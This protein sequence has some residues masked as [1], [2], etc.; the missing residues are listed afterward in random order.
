MDLYRIY[1]NDG[2]LLYVGISYST[3]QRLGQHKDTQHWFE[4][5]ARIERQ[6]LGDISRQ[7]ALAIEAQVITAER[8][9]YNK[10][11]NRSSQLSGDRQKSTSTA[12]TSRQH[13]YRWL[14]DWCA[15]VCVGESAYVLLDKE[16]NWH[17][18]HRKCDPIP[19]WASLYWFS[20]DRIETKAQ[21]DDWHRHMAGKQF[22]KAAY[23]GWRRL[24]KRGDVR[25]QAPEPKDGQG[26]WRR[27]LLEKQWRKRWFI[28][29]QKGQHGVAYPVSGGVRLVMYSWL[30][31]SETGSRIVNQ[32]EIDN[33]AVELF[34]DEGMWDEMVHRM[35]RD[36]F[37]RN[38]GAA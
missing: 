20:V 37:H 6:N 13:D 32:S 23:T 36:V 19:E 24:L 18:L 38:Q 28:D 9:Q 29:R 10:T 27:E 25:T 2:Q 4:S 17:V 34:D 21:A 3:I 14:C 1:G 7:E 30:D 33:G 12:G 26:A 11:H 15:N 5:V 8:P 35:A 22:W 31:D 16:Y